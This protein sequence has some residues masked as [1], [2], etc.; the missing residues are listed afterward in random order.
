MIF[1]WPADA[2]I[3]FKQVFEKFGASILP[4]GVASPQ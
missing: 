4:P 2:A 1:S 3:E